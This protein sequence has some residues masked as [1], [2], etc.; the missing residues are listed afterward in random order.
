MN[1]KSRIREHYDFLSPYFQQLWGVHIHHGYWQTGR[2]TKE[3]AQEQL[4][5]KLITRAGIK[6]GARILDVG[7]GIGGSAIYLN[8]KLNADVTGIT[9]SPTQ[10]AIAKELAKENEAEVDFLLMDAENMRF[11]KAFDIVWSIEAI[12]HLSH[13]EKFFKKC[14]EILKPE[15]KLI[16]TDWFRASNLK[17]SDQRRY[18]EPI[19]EAMVL[20]RIE[21]RNDYLR[22]LARA[23][24]RTALFE[25]MSDNVSRTWGISIELI[26][27][28]SLWKLA[29]KQGKQF[30]NFLRGFQAMRKGFATRSLV[31]GLILAERVL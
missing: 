12:S 15:G 13:K 24:F 11:K 26:K 3:R 25:E 8:K 4:I 18:I 6:N 21:S 19:E 9:I 29:A 31:Y 5:E 10:V 22:H 1:L 23:G 30:A 17:A 2:E 28:P 14:R 7:C 16:F 27:N 20:A